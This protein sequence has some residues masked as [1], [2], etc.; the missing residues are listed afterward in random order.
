M[1]N[2]QL[3]LFQSIG[4]TGM[5]WLRTS[6]SLG[7]GVG[8]GRSSSVRGVPTAVRTAAMFLSCEDMVN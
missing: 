6:I 4:L 2:P 7:P 1:A 3:C 5:Q 8:V